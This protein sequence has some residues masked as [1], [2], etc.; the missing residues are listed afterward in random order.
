M[1]S[2]LFYKLVPAE[3][4]L[5]VAGEESYSVAGVSI[6]VPVEQLSI[7]KVIGYGSFD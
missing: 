5:S 7:D 4:V 2:Y 1:A 6:S 3:L